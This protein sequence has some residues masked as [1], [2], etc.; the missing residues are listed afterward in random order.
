[1][2][3]FEVTSFIMLGTW[4]GG[5]LSPLLPRGRS[6]IRKQMLQC[7]RVIVGELYGYEFSGNVG[8][9]LSLHSDKCPLYPDRSKVYALITPPRRYVE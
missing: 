2:G 8:F 4:V 3:R 9:L 7:R 5:P 1:M 6:R